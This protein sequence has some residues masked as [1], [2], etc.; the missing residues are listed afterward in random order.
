MRDSVVVEE[1]KNTLH[2]DIKCHWRREKP[3]FYFLCVC[4]A[5][6]QENA[7]L[8]SIVNRDNLNFYST[9]QIFYSFPF[10]L[11]FDNI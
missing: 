9:L 3:I 6:E 10:S 8:P 4:T 1:K 5:F 11:K 7:F 2:A